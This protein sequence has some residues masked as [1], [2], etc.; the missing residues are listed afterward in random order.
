MYVPIDSWDWNARTDRFMRLEMPDQSRHCLWNCRTNRFMRLELPDQLRH[1]LWNWPGQWLHEAIIDLNCQ[2][3]WF[4]R[5]SIDCNCRTNCFNC[6]TN[7]FM[8][9]SIKWN[10]RDN[11][12]RRMSFKWNL[13]DNRFGRGQSI[14]I[15]FYNVICVTCCYNGYDRPLVLMPCTIDIVI[16]YC[17]YSRPTEKSIN[18]D[19]PDKWFLLVT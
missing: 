6:R 1:C 11:I 14:G 3:G 13:S 17:A 19:D 12:F 15:F 18:W 9:L 10:W 4:M 8:R 16:D 2:T 5:R 7:W